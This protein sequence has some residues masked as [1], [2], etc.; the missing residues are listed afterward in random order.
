LPAE[1][2]ALSVSLG[3]GDGSFHAAADY[4]PTSDPVMA[5]ALADFDR[6]GERDVLLTSIHGMRLLPGNGDG[7]FRSATQIDETRRAHG[8]WTAVADFSG[9]GKPDIAVLGG[10]ARHLDVYLNTT[11][12]AN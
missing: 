10:R 12:A 8:A 5:L 6:D 1:Y 3:T 7:S 2:P 4:D 9:D 11:G